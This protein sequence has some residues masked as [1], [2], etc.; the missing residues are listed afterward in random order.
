MAEGEGC[1][2]TL[3]EKVAIVRLYSVSESNARQ[4]RRLIYQN[5]VKEQKWSECGMEKAPIPSVSTIHRINKMFD[6]TG[7]VSKSMLQG[8]KRKRTVTTAEN[9]HL[10]AEEIF[11]SP[12]IPKSHRRLSNALKYLC[13]IL[14]I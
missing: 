6:E 7:C 1:K 12:N 10:V 11:R 2:I 8:R 14:K 9:M 13:K 4:T 3:Q 5:G